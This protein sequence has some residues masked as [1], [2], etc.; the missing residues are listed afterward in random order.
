[1]RNISKIG[2]LINKVDDLKTECRHVYLASADDPDY[3]AKI[4]PLQRK[5]FILAGHLA[6]LEA[7]L[8]SVLPE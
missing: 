5:L 3:V 1:M 7:E 6:D 4:E 8:I 2:K